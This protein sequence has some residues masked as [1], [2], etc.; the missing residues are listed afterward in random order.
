MINV[1]KLSTYELYSPVDENEIKK[2]EEEMGL[3]LPNAYKQLL[4]HTNGF[5]SDNG[6]VIFGVDIIDEMNKT[7]EVHEYAKGYVAVGSNGGGKILLMNANENATEL[8]QVDSGI[9]DPNYA[10]TVSENLIQ[11]INDGAID[12]DCVDEEQEVFK[13]KLCNL[14]LVSPPVGGAM[15]LKKIQEVFIIK[16]G[17]FDL[18]KGSKQ[19]PFVLM[20]DIPV[21]LA[22]K[23]IELLGELG[24]ILKISS[25]D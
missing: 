1:Q 11:W 5:V 7:Y 13:E 18:L 4:K 14:I 19:L 21:E 20:K 12:I 6:V 16:K 25:T 2:I 3:I 24:D 17:L 22:L 10:T 23:N 9:M 15:D 8:V